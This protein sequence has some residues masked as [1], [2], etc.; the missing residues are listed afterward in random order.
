[1]RLRVLLLQRCH[2]AGCPFAAAEPVGL[3]GG[4]A[5]WCAGDPDGA[6]RAGACGTRRGGH[7]AG[8]Q[9]GVGG[10]WPRM[11]AGG[12]RCYLCL[13]GVNFLQDVLG[14][15]LH[16]V[17]SCVVVINIGLQLLHIG[18]RCHDGGVQ[19]NII[20]VGKRRERHRDALDYSFGS[21]ARRLIRCA[22]NVATHYD[23]RCV[24]LGYTV[25]IHHHC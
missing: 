12:G 1:M 14:V 16:G 7:G 18:H 24:L 11:L 17:C 22:L 25:G 23:A 20:I 13:G 3:L 10:T 4:A 9:S 15:L 21:R 8:T 6:R 19:R 5:G 2:P